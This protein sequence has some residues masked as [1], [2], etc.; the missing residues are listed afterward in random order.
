[1]RG[2]FFLRCAAV[3]TV[4]GVRGFVASALMGTSGSVD[5][6]TGA[7]GHTAAQGWASF[8]RPD[9]CLMLS[10]P[11]RAVDRLSPSVK[12]IT[13]SSEGGGVYGFESCETP[14]AM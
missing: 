13:H 3:V 4:V 10:S 14:S 8:P 9:R 6:R 2:R 12:R 5:R 11:P 1:M 7:L